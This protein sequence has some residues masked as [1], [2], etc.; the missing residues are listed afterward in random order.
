MNPNSLYGTKGGKQPINPYVSLFLSV[1]YLY[2]W[3]KEHCFCLIVQARS[4]ITVAE[5]EKVVDYFIEVGFSGSQ[6]NQIVTAFPQVLCYPVEER[7]MLLF[8]YL[9]DTVGFAHSDLRDMILHRPNILG[10]TCGQVEQ[11]IG[12]FLANG[13]SNDEIMQL[14]QTSL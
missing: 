5:V 2:A 7:I 14:L 6:V 8:D 11:M 4:T 12:F 13:S 1:L 9:S 10:L 3:I